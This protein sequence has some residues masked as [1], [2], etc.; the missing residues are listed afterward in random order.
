MIV[1]DDQGLARHVFAF[2]RIIV[3]I[4]HFHLAPT[5]ITSAIIITLNIDFGIIQQSR[6]INRHH[7]PF[8]IAFDHTET[9]NNMVSTS[10]EQQPDE[11][12]MNA[13]R[14]RLLETGDW[15][16]IQKLLRAQLEES[17]WADDLKDLAKE[18]A[19]AQETPSLEG[20]IK[21]ITQTA[22]TMVGDGVRRDVMQE[23]EGVLDREV[24]QA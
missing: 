20:L 15:D 9:N 12:T 13:I 5:R 1:K 3:D 16:R 11:A 14:Q 4:L 2:I 23:I 24:D 22:Q 7:Q 17:G 18:K 19:R 8:G 21:E 10:A 6:L